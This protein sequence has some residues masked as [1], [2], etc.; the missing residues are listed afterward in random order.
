MPALEYCVVGCVDLGLFTCLI[1][2]LL[3]TWNFCCCIPTCYLLTVTCVNCYCVFGVLL[4]VYLL[5]CGLWWMGL[6]RYFGGCFG[7]TLADFGVC[8]LLHYD[9]ADCACW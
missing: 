5:M 9:S 4:V 7:V 3:I 6:L 1:C 8:Y 2:C